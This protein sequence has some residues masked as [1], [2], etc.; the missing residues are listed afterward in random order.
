MTQQ[1]IMLEEL[2][3]ALSTFHLEMFD[4]F[5]KRANI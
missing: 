2:K 4:N 3:L 1:N 5:Q